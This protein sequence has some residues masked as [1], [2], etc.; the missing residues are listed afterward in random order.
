MKYILQHRPSS[1][2]IFC[3]ALKKRDGSENLVIYRGEMV[4]VIMNRYPYTGGHLMVVPVIHQPTIEKL[5]S[6]VNDEIMALIARSMQ[7]IRKA[8]QPDGFNIGGN[9]GGAA[10]AG[11]TDHVHFHVVP[12][13]Y[14][15][16]NFMSTVGSTRVLP[17]DLASSYQRL[18]EAWVSTL[19]A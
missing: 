6:R 3:A 2:C 8:Y 1:E 12:R 9:I 15:D 19:T 11:V 10:G 14:G 5:E 16:T 7:V 13:W 17:E 18:C 4:F